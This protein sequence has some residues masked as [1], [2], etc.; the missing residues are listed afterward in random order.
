MENGRS[1]RPTI[2]NNITDIQCFDGGGDQRDRVTPANRRMHAVSADF[3]SKQ[4]GRLKQVCDKIEKSRPLENPYP[5]FPG[6]PS[7]LSFHRGRLI[8]LTTLREGTIAAAFFNPPRQTHMQPD[9]QSRVS[10]LRMAAILTTAFCL[11][12][13]AQDTKDLNNRPK[14][15][16]RV[17]PLVIMEH[18]LLTGRI[19]FMQE[20]ELD[21]EPGS[22]IDIAIRSGDRNRTVYRTRTDAQGLYEIPRLTSG[23]YWMHVGQLVLRLQVNKHTT[24][25]DGDSDS[26][27]TNETPGVIKDEDLKPKVL[28][29]FIP[30]DLA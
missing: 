7:L 19:V 14:N 13:P 3:K 25:E 11:V 26:S 29:I 2:Q 8:L 15:E 9:L 17:A 24:H 10:R 28:V 30:R 16:E 6:L 18:T 23:L 20:E 1:P 22:E 5:S 21:E 27:S 4:A 12:A